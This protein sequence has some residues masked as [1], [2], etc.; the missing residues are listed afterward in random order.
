MVKELIEW[1]EHRLAAGKDDVVVDDDE[2]ERLFVDEG[3]NRGLEK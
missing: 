1:L 3:E 2:F